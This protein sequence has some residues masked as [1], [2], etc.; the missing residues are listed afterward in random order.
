MSKDTEVVSTRQ[1]VEL[2]MG[3]VTPA[4]ED[5]EQMMRALATRILSAT[6]IDEIFADL[7]TTATRDLIGKPIV[8]RDAMVRK[9]ELED[10]SGTYMLLDCIDSETGEQ[11]T[12]NTG[13][14]QIM[15]TVWG[16]KLHGLLPIEVI[17]REAAKAKAGRSA[18]LRLE[19]IGATAQA[20]AGK[21]EEKRQ[22]QGQ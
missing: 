21:R 5:E 12:A 19:P 15:F 13:A 7:S 6:E 8:I 1:E 10:A 2:L 20:I 17:V 22:L 18:P 3:K 14:S 9:S 11:F 16:C 4:A